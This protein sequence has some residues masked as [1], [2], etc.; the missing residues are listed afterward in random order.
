MVLV[1][2]WLPPSKENWELV[3]WGFQFFP[4]ITIFQWTSTYYPAGKTSVESR[5]NI[6]GK[7]AWITMEVPGFLTLLYVMSTLP[8]ELGIKELPWENI[9]MGSLFV[10][11]Y[12]YRAIINPLL[13]PSMS[14]YHLLSWSLAIAFQLSNGLS[15]GGYLAGYG[16][17]TRS[18]WYNNSTHT[19][20]YMPAAIMELGFMIWGLGLAGNIYHDDEL[21]E[22][23]RAAQRK[24][25]KKLQ[26]A[27]DD[28]GK[29]Q[30]VDKVYMIPQNGMFRWIFFPHYLCEWIEWGGYWMMAGWGATPMRTFLVNEIT[31]MLPRAIAG[32]KWYLARF[33]EKEV[34]SRKAIIPGLI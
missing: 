28:K 10:I 33:G 9:I 8:K 25:D 13:N 5:L 22:I 7:I 15:I 23:R 21:R 18:D 11:H 16:P 4:L 20:S 29:K 19:A 3:V 34:G 14:P 24:L 31:T 12:L 1:Q 26:E 27:G 17:L 6:P 2:N 30:G 32:R